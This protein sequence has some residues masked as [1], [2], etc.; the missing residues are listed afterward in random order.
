M[1]ELGWD[2]D[3]PMIVSIKQDG[4]TVMKISIAEIIESSPRQAVLN[5]IAECDRTPWLTRWQN[6]KHAGLVDLLKKDYEA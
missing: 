1:S 5:H 2:I 4:K 3:T 6:E